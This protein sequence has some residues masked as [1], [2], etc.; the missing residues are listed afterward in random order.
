MTIPMQ[1]RGLLPIMKWLL[2][3][4]VRAVAAG[5]SR[6]D[7]SATAA[8]P[9]GRLH[10]MPAGDRVRPVATVHSGDRLPAGTCGSIRYAAILTMP[11]VSGLNSPHASTTLFRIAATGIYSGIRAIGKGFA[12]LVTR[13]R[14]QLRTADLAIDGA[15][16]GDPWC[17]ECEGFHP[18]PTFRCGVE[19]PAMDGLTMLV[20][21]TRRAA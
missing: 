16:G 11:M 2:P 17:E 1:A 8:S 14:Q 13:A 5:Q 9:Q 12:V 18:R 10:K 4:S 7:P 19:E 15:D 3:P 20:D 6:P 21:C